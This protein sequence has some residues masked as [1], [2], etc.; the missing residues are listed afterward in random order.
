MAVIDMSSIVFI[1]PNHMLPKTTLPN[2]PFATSHTGSGTPLR[3]RQGFG[4]TLLDNPPTV[5]VVI[6]T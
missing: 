2:T 4:K 3:N 5:G 6:I 1:V